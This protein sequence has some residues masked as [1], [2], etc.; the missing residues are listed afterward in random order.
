MNDKC[1]QVEMNLQDGIRTMVDGL[2]WKAD[3][4]DVLN[5]HVKMINKIESSIT[6]LGEVNMGIRM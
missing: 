4:V 6:G 1:L 3:K 2:S 5:S